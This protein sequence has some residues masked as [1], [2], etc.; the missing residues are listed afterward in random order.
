MSLAAI[1]ISNSTNVILLRT[2][3]RNPKWKNVCYLNQKTVVSE[4][5][6]HKGQFSGT[7]YLK[8][9]FTNTPAIIWRSLLR[10]MSFLS[11][12]QMFTLHI[13]FNEGSENID[14]KQMTGHP[15]SSLTAG[16]VAKIWLFAPDRHL[17]VRMIV[18]ALIPKKWII[19]QIIKVEL[20]KRNICHKL[21]LE[22][23]TVS[24]K[25]EHTTI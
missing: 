6:V 10:R 23:D 9:M 8:Q 15:S 2:F 25:T 14:D 18:R 22:I 24:G 19:H 12:F 11:T 16:N 17:N 13:T 7:K 1:S 3:Q 21:F 5:F 20:Q 4:K